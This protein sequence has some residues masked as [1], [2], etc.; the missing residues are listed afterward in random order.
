MKKTV[1]LFILLANALF[2][3][4]LMPNQAFQP[5]ANLQDNSQVIVNVKLGKDIYLHKKDFKISLQKGS[6][7]SIKDIKLSKS[8]TYNKEQIFE[9]SVRA[10]VTLAKQADIHGTHAIKIVLDF[11]G[12]SKMG[13]CYQPQHHVYDFTVN[14][15]KM[16]VK[17]TQTSK[18]QPL[19]QTEQ[20]AKTLSSNNIFW[21][22]LS[23][24]GFGL[25]LSL[26]PC[27]FPMIPIV[28]SIIVSQGKDITTKRAFFLSLVYVLAMAVA[29]TIAGIL[30]GL[31]GANLQASLQTPWVIYTFAAVFVLLSLSMFGLYELQ[32]PNFIQSKLSTQTNGKGGIIGVALMGFVSALIVGP[33]VAAPLAGALV[34]IGQTGNAL[35]GG[36]ALFALAIGMGVPLLIVGTG[37]GKFMP[38]PGIWMDRVNKFFGI[39]MLGVAVW[40]LSR[41]LAD[42]VTMLLWAVLGIGA[43]IAFGAMEPLHVKDGVREN[44]F[45]KILAFIV[46]LYSVFLFLGM[47]GG[48]KSYTKPLQ[49]FAAKSTAL[50]TNDQA[51]HFQVVTSLQELNT[52]LA[53]NKGKKVLLDFSAKWCVACKELEDKTFSDPHVAKAMQNFVL[54][55]A[56]LTKDGAKERALAKYYGIF[57]PPAILFFDTKGKQIAGKT[58]VGYVPPQTFL[59]HLQNL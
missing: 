23:F 42:E 26:T 19:S 58:I 37:A 1:F 4:F 43:A 33:C 10:V 25:L 20:I 2:A 16:G 3:N 48:S 28:S 46:L 18:A 34:Y 38:R 54:I 11:Q 30:A 35:L 15:D 39:L 31:F 51:L 57:G 13:V 24:F 21:T 14:T 44:S 5:S 27:V 12:C 49:V 6:G 17:T 56:D 8:K 45:I 55:R 9:N 47:L 41:V 32:M 59:T 53:K 22:L 40:M 29:Y 36:A 7:L 50:Q 52:L